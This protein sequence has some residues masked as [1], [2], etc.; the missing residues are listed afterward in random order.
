M[1]N[2]TKDYYEVFFFHVVGLLTKKHTLLLGRLVSPTHYYD[3][4]QLDKLVYSSNYTMNFPKISTC[5]LRRS[6]DVN[7]CE[8]SD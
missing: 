4:N 5:M 1:R 2:D 3:L 8:R 7:D 6:Y